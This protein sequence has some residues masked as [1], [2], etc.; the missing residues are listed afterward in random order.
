MFHAKT[1]HTYTMHLTMNDAST[2]N[3][4][5]FQVLH[6]IPFRYLYI[7][8]LYIA[9]LSLLTFGHAVHTIFTHEDLGKY[10]IFL[11]WLVLVSGFFVSQVGVAFCSG[12]HVFKDVQFS[13]VRGRHIVMT[14]S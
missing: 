10:Y 2:T 12:W 6:R 8:G 7:P 5:M 3:R 11:T 9:L 4:V 1:R 14:D 13:D